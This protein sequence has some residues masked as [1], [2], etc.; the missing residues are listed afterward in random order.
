MLFSSPVFLFAFLPVILIAYYIFPSKARKAFLLAAS[1]FFYAWG[2]TAYV[3]ILIVSIGLN[4]AA[5]L[6]VDRF[7]H[8]NKKK[9]VLAVATGGNLGLLGVFKYTNFIIEN[10]NIL[11][12]TL[13]VST[14]DPVALHFPIGIS[15]FTFKALSYLFDV[16]RGRISV[17]RNI[18]D[19]ALYISLFPHLLAGPIAR[20]EEIA[21]SLRSRTA[22]AGLFVS[23]IERF[24]FGL[25]KKMLIADS[26]E[27]WRIKF[28]PF[29]R[30]ISPLA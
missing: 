1:L 14:L 8:S 22:N 19:V 27:G 5:G 2:E 9:W 15:F 18:L 30:Q 20:F 24:I 6:C 16:Y 28:F 13:T 26:L 23:G 11:L 4:Y 10:I 17:Q 25:A 29:L 3:T 7:K 12:S 21:E